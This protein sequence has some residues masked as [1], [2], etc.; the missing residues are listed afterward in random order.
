[1]QEKR[2]PIRGAPLGAV[3]LLGEGDRV[4]SQREIVHEAEGGANVRIRRHLPNVMPEPPK[5]QTNVVHRDWMLCWPGWVGP[6]WEGKRGDTMAYKFKA[7]E[8]GRH[9]IR[10]CAREQLD[11]AVVEL[12]DGVNADPVEAVHSARKA[13]K[14]ERS[15]LRLA[16]GAM[17]REQRRRENDILRQAARGLSGARDADVM[18]ASICELSERYAGQ[19]PAETFEAVRAHF[20]ARAQPDNGRSVVD[21]RAV[22]E[23][24]AVRDRVADW[25]LRKGGWKALESGLLRSYSRGR[26]TFAHAQV[27][28]EMEALHEWRKRVKDLWYHE[29]LLGPTCGP[30]V[31]GHVKDLDRLSDLLGDDHDLALLRQE[32][33]QPSAPVPVDLDAVVGLVDHRRNELQTE[34]TRIGERVYAETP[35][36][37]RR[38]MRESWRAGRRL[39]RAPRDQ[40]PAQLAAATR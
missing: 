21:G 13:I 19:L 2:R 10:R 20:E 22:A 16:R 35:K 28:G 32:L 8:S 27:S 12:R 5:G 36:A 7:D 14:K 40:R 18:I 23:L 38:R 24:T 31:R 33:T 1:M 4:P 26:Q 39:A 37:Y 30:T 29:R 34:A 9:A 11:R 15:L 3:V 17:P 6:S 25:Q